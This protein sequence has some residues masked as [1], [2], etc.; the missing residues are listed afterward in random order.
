MAHGSNDGLFDEIEI[1]TPQEIRDSKEGT[2]TTSEETEENTDGLENH[3][4]DNDFIEVK[5]REVIET[6]DDEE[7]IEDETLTENTTDDELSNK[8]KAFAKELLDAGLLEADEEGE[9]DVDSVDKLK[10]LFEKT[11]EKKTGSKFESFKSNFS[12]AKKKFLEIEDSFSDDT[13]AIN[14]A[15]DLTYYSSIDADNMTDEQAKDINTR[16]LKAK[17]F[18]DEEITAQLDDNEIL[19]KSIEK[20]KKALPWLKTSTENYVEA[21]AKAKAEEIEKRQAQQS[22]AVNRVI[23]SIDEKEYFIKGLPLNK[24][25]KDKIKA[26]M[27]EVVHTDKQGN[28]FTDLAMKQ[29]KNPEEF[30]V[31]LN[32]YN[33]LGLFNQNAKGEFVPDISK[34]KKISKTRAVNELDKVLS[35][36]QTSTGTNTVSNG[37]KNVLSAIETL[38]KKK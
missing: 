16:Y 11:L 25:T 14:V 1:M 30:A 23:T 18:S 21:Q 20:A 17:G 22:N 7:T 9:L 4:N 24:V 29:N 33:A 38:F 27:T 6:T 37:S 12:G 34:I 13:L 32:Y 15:K 26:S 36:R 10:E 5:P 35:S 2:S 3:E 8:Y 31:M 19:D 28:K